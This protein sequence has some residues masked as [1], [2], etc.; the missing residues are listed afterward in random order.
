MTHELNLYI[1]NGEFCVRIVIL[2]LMHYAYS[3]TSHLFLADQS[4]LFI[5]LE[6]PGIMEGSEKKLRFHS[7]IIALLAG[8][9]EGHQRSEWEIST[10]EE[11]DC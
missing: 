1:L 5:I 9:T 6:F 4:W 3:P 11:T 8:S 7:F 2:N 10:L